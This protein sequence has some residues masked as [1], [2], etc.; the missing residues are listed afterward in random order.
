MR[1]N[2][3][4][5]I[6]WFLFG[7]LYSQELEV[8]TYQI[9]V[10]DSY[11]SIAKSFGISQKDLKIANPKL[12]RKPVLYSEIYVPYN[13]ENEVFIQVKPKQTLYSISRE[14]GIPVSEILVY[15]D[16]EQPLQIGVLLKLPKSQMLSSEEV[17]A[18][19]LLLE[20]EFD[21]YRVEE[22]DT[23]EELADRFEIS[24]DSLEVWNPDVLEFGLM[25]GMLI[26]VRRKTE[27][28][29]IAEE[30]VIFKDSIVASDKTFHLD[31]MLPLKLKRNDTLSPLKTFRKKGSVLDR[32]SDYYLGAMMA[33]DSLKSL[34]LDI[35]YRVY[36]TEN[37]MEK[38]Q[39][40]VVFEDFENTDLIVGPFYSTKAEYV[41]SRLGD[42]PI[43][44]PMYSKNQRNFKASNFIKPELDIDTYA[45]RLNQYIVNHYCDEHMVIVQDTTAASREQSKA[46]MDS[47]RVLDPNVSM[48]SLV[49]T[50][51]NVDMESF[52]LAIDS[53]ATNNWVVMTNYGT[54]AS[55]LIQNI[56]ALENSRGRL[57][58]NQKDRYFKESNDVLTRIDFTYASSSFT[59]L[60]D[61]DTRRFYRS[62][63][64][65]Y[66][67][68]PTEASI[69]GFDEVYDVLM[70]YYSSVD[71]F[72]SEQLFAG[73]SKRVSN[74]YLYRLDEQNIPSNKE[75]FIMRYSMD[76]E[77]REE[78]EWVLNPNIFGFEDLVDDED[79]EEEEET[80][81]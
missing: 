64:K 25:E 61:E 60:S 6:I 73:K 47:L 40:I 16:V 67:A 31:F 42:K 49:A 27:L 21:V 43:L 55:A 54:T 53:L 50:S 36:D 48:S 44:F 35:S 23:L 7:N 14:Y 3:A 2:I 63:Q 26:K 38:V 59:N 79:S 33:I 76:G 51:N 12:S 37:N 4:F 80:E 34:G 62:Y 10:G 15:N 77:I 22:E 20:D 74:H 17:L 18:A 28:V 78:E 41:A 19:E 65:R 5:V 8:F 57:F 75:V 24:Q 66:K 69:K 52:N 29:Y 56:V 1:K 58:A 68:Y 9:Q 72:E 71:G 30:D 70:R 46:L 39:E 11:K 13:A 45:A 81:K 32:V